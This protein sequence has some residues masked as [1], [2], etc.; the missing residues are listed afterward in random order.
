MRLL[1]CVLLL[2]SMCMVTGCVYSSAPVNAPIV[3]GE[4]GAFPVAVDNSVASSKVSR[5]KA[6]GILIVGYG[7]ASIDTAMKKEG[8]KKVHHI[9]VEVLNV[10]GVYS[11][12][13]LVVYGE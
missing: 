6:E 10:I 1:L 9:D 11:R 4:K 5:V 7:D 12:Y 2:L 13:E 8:I 3:A